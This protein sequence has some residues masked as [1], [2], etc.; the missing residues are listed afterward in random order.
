MADSATHFGKPR[1]PK[2][3]AFALGVGA[4]VLVLG[5]MG[6][7]CQRNVL[8]QSSDAAPVRSSGNAVSIEIA[9]LQVT[10]T[11]T[12]DEAVQWA[13]VEVTEPA[14]KNW[15]MA[16]PKIAPL[17]AD[18]RET[19]RTELLSTVISPQD[20]GRIGDIFWR[21]GSDLDT[22][23]VVYAA[24]VKEADAQLAKTT[25]SAARKHLLTWLF[26]AETPLWLAQETMHDIR[27]V[28]TLSLL[29]RDMVHYVSP[30]ETDEQLRHCREDG[31]IG[32]AEVL[33]VSGNA[34]AALKAATAIDDSKF[35]ATGKVGVAWIRG[36]C[37]FD[38]ER[39]AE[40]KP[41]FQLVADRGINF[42]HRPDA[43]AL[44][45]ACLLKTGHWQEGQAVFQQMQSLP[46]QSMLNGAV[47]RLF[48][49]PYQGTQ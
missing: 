44:L 37:L 46:V 8:A 16:H 24:G 49:Q 48:S 9:S 7:H 1:Q 47:M 34:S 13:G 3:L 41:Q 43:M 39:W 5:G 31:L 33:Y 38:A 27:V 25:D 30:Q 20:L 4:C 10:A 15:I 6:W 23:A 35:F 17:T 40:A 32:S 19:L 28:P 29:D 21:N 11:P 2:R 36:L 42:A 12:L 18:D 22:G 26:K 14:M 45:T